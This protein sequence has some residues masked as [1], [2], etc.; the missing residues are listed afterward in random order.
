MTTVSILGASGYTG[1]ELL[2]LL[3]QHPGVEV[4]GATSAQFAGEYLHKAH[5]NLRGRTTLKFVARHELPDADVVFTCVPHGAAM[6]VVPGLVEKGVKVIDLSADFR[7][8][9]PKAY[10]HWYGAS[11]KAPDLLAKAAY[12]LPEV[13]REAIRGAQLVS[14]VG[15][16]ATAINL[17]L[18]PLA[19]AGLLRTGPAVC[20]IKIGSSASG[21]EATI[22]SIHAERSRAI[23]LYA[24]TRHRHV[25]EVQQALALQ[26]ATT[27]IHYSAHAVE[28]VRGI[29]ATC[30]AF[31]ERD[32]TEKE[33]W[34]AYRGAFGSEPFVRFVKERTGIHRVPDPKLVAGS[35][36]AD[37]GFELEEG[38]RRVVATAAIDNLVKGAAGSAV[39][40]M[41]LMLGL[42]ETT[43]LMQIPLHPV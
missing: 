26:G 23:R 11:H 2:R 39:Q 34:Q 30:H 27:A 3:L 29:L 42:D 24:P 18:H 17:A 20:D 19:K 9:D 4:K 35:N 13:N 37:L 15:C 12:G 41:N 16:T 38:T 21:L 32:V 36:Y 7:L 25:A 43:G 5:P 28:L 8:K 1:G 33:L 10:E 22:G 31:V 14:G 6:A 40:C